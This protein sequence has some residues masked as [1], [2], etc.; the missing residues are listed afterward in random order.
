MRDDFHFTCPNPTCEKEN[1]VNRTSNLEPIP[2]YGDE[3]KEF[4][5]TC[6][7]CFKLFKVE[8][9]VVISEVEV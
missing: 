2:E 1:A 3:P 4:Y 6:G 9:I 8:Y 5:V 7:H